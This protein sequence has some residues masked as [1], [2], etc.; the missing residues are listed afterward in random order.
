MVVTVDTNV[1]IEALFFQNDF[2]LK[3]LEEESREKI[4]FAMNQAMYT[5]LTVVYM[6]HITDPKISEERRYKLCGKLSSVIWRVLRTPHKIRTKFC[7]EDSN[8]NKFIDCAI[9]SKSEYLITLNH[10]HIKKEFE[11]LIKEQYNHK[12]QIVDPYHFV[13]RKLMQKYNS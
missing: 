3:I 4:V 12:L 8:D 13:K 2:C 7:T 1:I 10:K 6:L 9:E 5:E 11:P